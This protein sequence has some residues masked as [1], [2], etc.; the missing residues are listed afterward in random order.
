MN[1]PYCNNKETNVLESRIL[2]DGGG[3][4]RRREC[5]K[6][7]K[8]FTTFE[9]VAN[10]DLKV[11]KKDGRI[12]DF[13]R[14]KVKKGIKKACWKRPVAEEQ[15][16][17]LVDNVEMKLL[18]R[19][20]TRIP[21]HDIGKMILSRLMKLDDVAYLRFASVYLDFETAVDFAKLITNLKN[22]HAQESEEKSE[23]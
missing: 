4:R 12:E 21:S 23:S 11:I 8:R 20:S 16:E 2:P 7:N 6:C 5:R 22:S 9:R 19:R 1:C 15:I 13:D 10:L 17:D 14:E 18:N 3:M